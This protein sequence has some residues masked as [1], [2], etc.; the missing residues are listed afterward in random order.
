MKRILA[1]GALAAM[2]SVS[3]Q[4]QNSGLAADGSNFTGP[5]GGGGGATSTVG[6][7]LPTASSG[8]GGGSLPSGLPSASGGFATATGP[9][10]VSVG[11]LSV[12]ISAAAQQAVGNAVVSGNTAGFVSSLGGAVPS[13]QAQA[14]GGALSGL[15]TAMRALSGGDGGA[16]AVGAVTTALNNAIAAFNAAV[17]ALPPGSP[18]PQSLIAAR[19]LIAG[20]Y[21]A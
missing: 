20:Y 13:T 5:G 11:G 17:S 1:A 14:L 7:F 8:A 3:A 18:V 21:G 15:G 12:S 19:A 10:N 4:G 2:I 6:A 16:A 9:A